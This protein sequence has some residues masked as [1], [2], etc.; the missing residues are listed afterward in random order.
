MS[1]SG[2]CELLPAVWPSAEKTLPQTI[3]ERRE[4]KKSV[5]GLLTGGVVHIDHAYTMLPDNVGMWSHE[6]FSCSLLN[7]SVALAW[8]LPSKVYILFWESTSRLVP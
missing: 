2:D 1:Y 6:M 4:G 7:W 5:R 3:G 8:V